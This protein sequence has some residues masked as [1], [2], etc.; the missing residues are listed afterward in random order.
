MSAPGKGRASAH[1]GWLLL[2]LLASASGSGAP[3]FS[4][5]LTWKVHPDFA[6]GTRVVEFT[7]DTAFEMDLTAESQCTYVVGQKVHCKPTL[8]GSARWGRLCVDQYDYSKVS[9]DDHRL[10]VI[11]DTSVPGSEYDSEADCLGEDNEFTVE[12]LHHINGANIVLGRLTHT[13]TMHNRAFAAMAF[14]STG[15]R[16][17][18]VGVSA[19]TLLPQCVNMTHPPQ[20]TCFP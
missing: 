7:L 1:T 5:S 18:D 20:V 10:Q 17:A 4:G 8:D 11:P 2:L 15:R 16:A 3:L 14:L 9:E 13:L 6:A 19:G 12:S